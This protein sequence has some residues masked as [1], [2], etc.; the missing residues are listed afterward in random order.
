MGGGQGPDVASSNL[1]YPTSILT[2]PPSILNFEFSFFHPPLSSNNSPSL[3]LLPPSTVKR[4]EKVTQNVLKISGFLAKCL[5]V[6]FSCKTKRYKKQDLPEGWKNKE[7][8]SSQIATEIKV[9]EIMENTPTVWKHTKP[10]TGWKHSIKEEEFRSRNE[11]SNKQ[12]EGKSRSSKKLKREK[13]E[14]Q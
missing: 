4:T 14:I 9:K 7:N 3:N 2:H 5:L 8:Y 10:P 13:N 1:D 12:K 11:N 6:A